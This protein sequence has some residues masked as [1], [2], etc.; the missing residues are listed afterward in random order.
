M[1]TSNDFEVKIA[2]LEQWFKLHKWLPEKIG[3]LV[4]VL[5]TKNN[6]FDTRQN[7]TD[8]HFGG[9]EISAMLT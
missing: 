8:K 1:V 2:E 6:E 7:I 9:C 4:L 5:L 3:E